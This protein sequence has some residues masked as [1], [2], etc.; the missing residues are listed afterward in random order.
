M[1]I[2]LEKLKTPP[3]SYPKDSPSVQEKKKKYTIKT[4]HSAP[5][6]STRETSKES[7]QKLKKPLNENLNPGRWKEDRYPTHLSQRT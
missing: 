6:D 5:E 4:C 1:T 7:S 3:K 2:H